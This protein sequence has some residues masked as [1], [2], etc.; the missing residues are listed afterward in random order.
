MVPQED[1]IAS[2]STLENMNSDRKQE[3]EQSME[4]GGRVLF[5]FFFCPKL[6]H[7]PHPSNVTQ[8]PKSGP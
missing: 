3:K 1:G 4:L 5:F 2:L 6:V 8:A 7:L